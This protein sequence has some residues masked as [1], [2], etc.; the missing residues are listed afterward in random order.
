LT[1]TLIRSRTS[2]EPAARTPVF[3]LLCES[4]K[5]AGRG[6]HEMA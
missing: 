2:E 3:A 5:A 1:M 4:T 6:L